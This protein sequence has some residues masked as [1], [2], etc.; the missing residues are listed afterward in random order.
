MPWTIFNGSRSWPGPGKPL[1]TP[2]DTDAQLEL[3]AYEANLHRGCGQPLDE[4][5][6][7]SSQDQYR[8]RVIACHACAEKQKTERDLAAAEHPEPGLIVIVERI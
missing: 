2:E 1:F 6:L 8:S 7:R 3:A 5:T 4:S